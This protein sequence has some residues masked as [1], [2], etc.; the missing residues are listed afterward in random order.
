MDWRFGWG[1]EW[2]W[3][4]HGRSLEKLRGTAAL[5]DASGSWRAL[6]LRELG[7]DDNFFVGRFRAVFRRKA[8]FYWGFGSLAVVRQL[9]WASQLYQLEIRFGTEQAGVSGW[10]RVK[11]FDQDAR[12]A[13]ADEGVDHLLAVFHMLFLSI[14]K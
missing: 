3:V 4:F 2:V 14:F 9:G 7:W 11:L 1:V 10:R 12:R 13:D 8:R 6:S 5:H